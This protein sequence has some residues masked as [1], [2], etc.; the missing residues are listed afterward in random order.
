MGE[1]PVI[2]GGDEGGGRGIHRVDMEKE[3]KGGGGME[4]EEKDDNKKQDIKGGI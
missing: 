1:F 4:R 3:V 2:R